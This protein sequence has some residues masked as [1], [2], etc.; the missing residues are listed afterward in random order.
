LRFKLSSGSFSGS[1]MAGTWLAAPPGRPASVIHPLASYCEGVHTLD[2][3]AT[4]TSAERLV[5]TFVNSDAPG[6]AT[7]A[8]TGQEPVQLLVK[9]GSFAGN[10]LR[11]LLVAW[12]CMAGLAALGLTAGTIFS[13]PVAAFVSCSVV[14]MLLIGHYDTTSP[15]ILL[16]E[17]GPVILALHYAGT[18]IAH[19]VSLIGAPAIAS[20]PVARL[21]DGI[22]IPTGHAIGFTL[23]LA[24]GY[25][26]AFG[27]LGGWLLGR[28][29]IA[30]PEV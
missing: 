16:P 27:L 20:L 22:L 26:L 23:L 8:F 3:P 29:E 18:G 10:L 30:V 1:D 28:R 17:G 12:G 21:A 7:A 25:P 6:A 15:D 9:S 19:A 5:L 24:F 4:V 11:A 13:F 14:L 2:L